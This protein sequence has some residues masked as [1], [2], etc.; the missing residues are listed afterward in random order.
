MLHE[1]CIQS[2]EIERATMNCHDQR[3]PS[4]ASLHGSRS[5]VGFERKP[6][7]NYL[8]VLQPFLQGTGWSKKKRTP[9]PIF[10]SPVAGTPVRRGGALV[11]RPATAGPP[12]ATPKPMSGCFMTRGCSKLGIRFPRRGTPSACACD[13][14]PVGCGCGKFRAFWRGNLGQF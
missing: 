12:G 2:F 4:R 8:S 10:G 14:L 11:R 7:V 1:S 5:E 13:L 3:G 9:G 6:R